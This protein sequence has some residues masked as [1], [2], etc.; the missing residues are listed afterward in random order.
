M[1]YC[2]T[3]KINYEAP[4][5]HCL[6]CSDSLEV[7]SELEV[8]NYPNYRAKSKFSKYFI[9]GT[10]LLNIMSIIICLSVNYLVSKNFTWSL[11]VS[12]S[13]LYVI[14]FVR[15]LLAESKIISRLF[16]I[17]AIS[18]LELLAI[19]YLTNDIS[20][21]IEIVLPF[22]LMLNTIILVVFTFAKRDNWQDYTLFLILSTL[23]N[24]GLIVLP[25][26][27][28]TSINWAIIT[29]FFVGFFTL[30]LLLIFTPRN[31]KEEFLRRFHI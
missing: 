5:E 24:M 14:L 31:L 29:S 27:N 12:V 17:I 16:L 13:N 15:L 2:K 20:W 19:A 10:F 4:I 7:T 8:N 22:I 9:K 6:L 18:I 28:V 23:T 11:I 30:L 26:L 21:A 3:C 25:I 1:K